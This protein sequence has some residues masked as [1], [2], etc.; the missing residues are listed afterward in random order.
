MVVAAGT[1][2]PLALVVLTIP[3]IFIA[4]AFH[5]LCEEQPN[6]GSTYA[7]A[8][9]VFRPTLGAFAAWIVVLSYFFAAV[10]SV[11]PAGIYSLSLLLPRYVDN[12]V[13]V[14]IAGSVWVLAA[15]ALL[16]GGVRPTAR[17]T[18]VFL[19]LEIVALLVFVGIAFAHAPVARHAASGFWNLGNAGVAGFLAAMVLAIWVTDGWEV[20]TYVS[21]ENAGSVREPGYGGLIGLIATVAIIVLCLVAFMRVG[22]LAGFSQHA[23]DS[24]AY[25]AAQVG[26]QW[27][28]LVMVATVLVSTAATLWTTQLGISRGVFAMARDGLFP[29]ALTKVHPRFRTPFVSIA[30][31]NAGVL[32][33]TLLT[34]LAPTASAALK[35]VINATSIFLGLTFIVTGLACVKRFSRAGVKW[36]DPTRMLLPA[37]GTLAIAALLVVNFSG[38]SPLDRAVA[39]ASLAIGVVYAL[40]QRRR[41]RIVPSAGVTAEA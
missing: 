15:S 7:W 33:V 1:G 9:S 21:E 39:V 26:G 40:W 29:R 30:V 14:A 12:A 18:A 27:R 28:T 37:I 17:T 41:E 35:E 10:A 25:V 36:S 34:G 38:Q 31:V 23:G 6:A 16:I 3:V 24:L 20:S 32:V 19:F 13:A 2:A 22:T 5:R 4:I 8:R 11:V